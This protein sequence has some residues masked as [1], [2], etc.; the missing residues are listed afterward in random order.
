[1]LS[2]LPL[3]AAEGIHYSIVV[4]IDPSS[5]MLSGK[6]RITLPAADQLELVL[7]RR[8]TVTHLQA[9]GVHVTQQSSGQGGV[10]SWRITT[11]LSSEK[12]ELRQIT[13]HW[14][15]A[16]AELD[17][18][19]DHAQTLGRPVPVSGA[20]G[21]FLPDASAWYPFVPGALASY[22]VEL[23]LPF[24]QR[25]LVAGKLVQESESESETDGYHASFIFEHPSD[26]IDL[27]AGPYQISHSTIRSAISAKEIRL[28]TYFHPEIDGLARDYLESV[29]QYIAFYEQWIGEYPFTEFSVVSS[30]TPTG[31]GMPT[32]TYLGV[33]VLK[34][35]FIRATSLGHEVLH[36]W[37]GN[38]VYADYSRGN[39]SE[40]LTTFM[41]D[42]T[43]KVQQ[44]SERAREMRLDWLRDF[45]ALAPGQDQPLLTFTSR[46]HGASKIV[47][48]NKAAMFFL[49]LRDELGDAIFDEAVRA[50]WREQRF[51]VT[52][53]QDIQRIFERIAKRSLDIYFRQWLT[54]TGAP[55]IHIAQAKSRAMKD[56]RFKLTVVLT[57]A[58]AAYQLRVPVMVRDRSGGQENLFANLE[59]TQQT[60]EWI[61]PSRPVEVLLDPG[62]QLFRLLAAEEAPPILR[63]GMVNQ[64]AK[65][66]L[67]PTPD[68]ESYR[69]AHDLVSSLQGRKPFLVNKQL[70]SGQT[71]LMVAGLTQQVN[72][73]LAQQGLPAMPDTLLEDEATAYVWATRASGGAAMII[74]SARD[75]QSLLALRRSLPHYGRQSY[76]V[77]DGATVIGKG[78]WPAQPPAISVSDGS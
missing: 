10:Q 24:G 41:A 48:Y 7:S 56:G 66:I 45:T 37:W 62:F 77:Y 23:S 17:Q 71:P 70:D 54:R 58:G 52:A 61:L 6:S 50:L 35:P 38:G 31:F 60:F 29:K 3:Q 11:G 2:S 39:W 67:L 21:T 69:I 51:R 16:L 22:Q 15:G 9:E 75:N 73:W 20:E 46:T 36:N 40:G 53:W 18:T 55:R 30:P 26:G 28:S 64:L 57:Q 14:Q 49:M 27:M 5:R 8:F 42:Y 34:L 68:S 47:G 43:Y 76:L 32:L 13:L 25:G 4:T 12:M 1:M 59:S 33:N 72:H 74:I 65:T 63:E 44:G 78:V 19:L